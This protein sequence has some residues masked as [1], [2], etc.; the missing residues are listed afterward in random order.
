MKFQELLYHA[1]DR[2]QTHP[3]GPRAGFYLDF[4]VNY[5]GKT[6]SDI[7]YKHKKKL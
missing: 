6:V 2:P 1:A 4:T 3:F 7:R 5:A